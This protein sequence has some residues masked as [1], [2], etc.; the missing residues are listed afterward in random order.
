MSLLV[1]LIISTL[2][3]SAG[4]KI[5]KSSQ[6]AKNNRRNFRLQKE[7]LRYQKRVQK[8]TWR[9]ED[10]A[11]Q[12]RARDMTAAGINPML[13]AGSPAQASAPISVNAPQKR[14]NPNIPIDPARIVMGAMNMMKMD[15]NIAQTEA[16][17]KL[18]NTQRALTQTENDIKTYDLGLAKFNKVP[19]QNNSLAGKYLKDF[20]SYFK[21]QLDDDSP[22]GKLIKKVD[23]KIF[24]K[25]AQ[26][27]KEKS[28]LPPDDQWEYEYYPIPKSRNGASGSY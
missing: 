21:G 25:G 4:M 20:G 6:T 9:R 23:E 7:Q 22:T 2:A 1:P 26:Y 27:E 18:S 10:N 3:G 12:R 28:L 17:T 24:P 8:T 13:A 16:Q 15:K 5:A 14:I 19:Y 11:V